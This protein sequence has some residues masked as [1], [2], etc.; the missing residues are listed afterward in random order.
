M[1]NPPLASCSSCGGPA[2][3]GGDHVHRPD[4]IYRFPLSGVD[5]FTR[6]GSSAPRDTFDY[7]DLE[8]VAKETFT[9]V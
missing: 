1:A 7:G 4:C 2:I 9:L 3:P 8:R 6:R 5:R